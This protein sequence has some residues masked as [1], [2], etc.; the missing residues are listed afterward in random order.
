MHSS[1][2]GLCT[3]ARIKWAMYTWIS[4][5]YEEYSRT[6]ISL[7]RLFCTSS[8]SG[9]TNARHL[10]GLVQ[11][12]H[13]SWLWSHVWCPSGLT[14]LSACLIQWEPIQALSSTLSS[15]CCLRHF[16][17]IAYL[18]QFHQ[19]EVLAP[20]E[21]C[22]LVLHSVFWKVGSNPPLLPSLLDRGCPSLLEK[23]CAYDV[24]QAI[25]PTPWRYRHHSVFTLKAPDEFG[26][27]V[28]SNPLWYFK[29]RTIIHF[30]VTSAINHILNIARP[31]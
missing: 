16:G 31:K 27:N 5:M 2:I 24:N 12:S 13:V 11:N 17:T 7:S 29:G 20:L 6:K 30:I 1:C 10:C 8:M 22:P 18:L 21:L 23:T 14:R 26:R 28:F 4:C 3:I 15:R 19:V 9:P 25:H